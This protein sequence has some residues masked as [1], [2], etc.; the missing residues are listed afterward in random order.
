MDEWMDGL[1]NRF[2]EWWWVGECTPYTIWKCFIFYNKTG[3]HR[4][5]PQLCIFFFF[6]HWHLFP[7]KVS[8]FYLDCMYLLQPIWF[9]LSVQC[10]FYGPKGRTKMSID[11]HTTA[12]MRLS[13]ANHWFNQSHS[14]SYLVELVHCFSYTTF[15]LHRAFPF[16]TQEAF[17]STARSNNLSSCAEPKKANRTSM[18]ALGHWPSVR[19]F[20]RFR[21]ILRFAQPAL[22]YFRE[23]CTLICSDRVCPLLAVLN[24]NR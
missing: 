18:P 17:R 13:I 19:P 12:R 16:Y 1:V 11:V 2:N 10:V 20:I 3:F 9:D 21:L 24:P 15:W 14:F 6:F 8:V 22:G 5:T 23:K 7:F 4:S